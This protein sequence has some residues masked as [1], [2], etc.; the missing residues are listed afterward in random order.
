MR[1]FRATNGYLGNG[2]VHCYIIAEHKHRALAMAVE[3]FKAES[4]GTGYA[5][6]GGRRVE[7]SNYYANVQVEL[8]C[9]DA[10]IEWTGEISD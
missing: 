4:V 7:D 9:N 2:D 3:K 5:A 6:R 8:V 1:L 10:T